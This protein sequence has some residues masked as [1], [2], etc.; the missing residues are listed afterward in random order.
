MAKTYIY[1]MEFKNKKYNWAGRVVV[2]DN[3][4]VNEVINQ[5]II[6]QLHTDEKEDDLIEFTIKRKD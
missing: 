6:D 2:P 5:A 1:T 4:S 3:T